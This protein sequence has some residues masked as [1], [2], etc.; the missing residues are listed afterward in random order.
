MTDHWRPRE[1]WP[2]RLDEIPLGSIIAFD[3]QPYRLIET[4]ERPYDLWPE[5]YKTVH[6]NY[7]AQCTAL[8]WN[9][10]DHATWRARPLVYVL[11]RDGQPAAK[12]RHRL[13]PARSLFYVLPEHYGLCHRCGEVPPC[14]EV[15]IDRATARE[16]ERME[17]LMSILPGHCLGCGQA[18]THRHEAFRY[19]GPNLWRPDLGDDSAVFHAARS[20][21]ECRAAVADYDHQWAS[22]APGRRRRFACEGNFTVHAD[23]SR[24][25]T[26]G[27]H[28]PLLAA[29][30]AGHR[31]DVQHSLFVTHRR[32]VY[33]AGDCW[34]LAPVEGAETLASK[35]QP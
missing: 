30:D 18:V 25:C 17:R 9:T 26:S 1:G 4:S 34:C 19:P 10:P 14:R 11:Q 21:R 27:E 13:A 12:L 6:A 31:E 28:C 8:G 15:E 7:A 2:Q 35:G 5:Q 23:G 20:R 3:R 24:D 16:T 32:G 22:A 33:G 29:F